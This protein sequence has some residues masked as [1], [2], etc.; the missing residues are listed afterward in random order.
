MSILH[1][2]DWSYANVAIV[3]LQIL[4]L[5]AFSGESSG[6]NAGYS[7]FADSNKSLKVSSRT[8]ML[9]LYAPAFVVS[10]YYLQVAPKAYGNGREWITALL[11]SFHFGK[12]LLECLFVHKYSG[13]MDADFL[14]PI[15]MS[16]ALTA[17]LVAHQQLQVQEYSHPMSELFCV[18]GLWLAVIGQAGNFFHH[19]LLA[20]LR[21][22]KTSGYTIP[23]GGLFKFVT[24][25]H[26]LCE[27]IAWLGLA[28]V[29][30]QL[31]AFLT[32]A[33][34]TSYLA[35]RSVATTRWYKSKFPDYPV[36]RKHL[37]PFLF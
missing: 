20:R 26:Y 19:Y 25:P 32:V 23:S 15:S 6:Q 31:N 10:L 13:T 37:I 3:T 2:P 16:Y 22:D 29:T 34:M 8:G 28:C 17:A 14:L 35:G 36:E 18:I 21:K 24:A 12:R 33:D 5:G 7:K 4:G 11:L 9:A 1:L 30:Q 27:L